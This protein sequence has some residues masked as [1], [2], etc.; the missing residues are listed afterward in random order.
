MSWEKKRVTVITKAYPEPSTKHGDVACT[1]GITDAGDWIRLYPIDMRLFVGEGKISKF[2]VIEVECEKDRDR[3]GRKESHKI[4]PDS[5]R[6]VDRS[7]SKPGADW[8][9]RNNVLLPMVVHSVEELQ[10][11]HKE[12]KTSLGIIKPYEVIDFIKTEPLEIQ[13]QTSWSFTLT[14]DGQK[15]PNVTK[16]KHI[17]KYR[18]RCQRCPDGSDHRMQCEDWELFES[19]RSWG[20]R[21][22]DPA[23]LWEKSRERYLTWMLEKRDLHFIM[24]THSQYPT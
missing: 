21:Y 20:H 10:A 8:K 11:A 13:E 9:R 19:Y 15:I 3:L 5:I 1:A 22:R 16:M 2:D 17:F 12:D 7:L 6:I 4:R 18:F 14:L 24:G 23:I